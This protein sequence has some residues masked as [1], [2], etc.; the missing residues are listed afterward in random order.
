MSVFQ[1]SFWLWFY[2]LPRKIQDRT[3][4]ACHL[5]MKS[6]I[7][8]SSHGLGEQ[9]LLIDMQNSAH[10][11]VITQALV[12]QFYKRVRLRLKKPLTQKAKHFRTLFLF[13]DILHFISFPTI[14]RLT[15]FDLSRRANN[16][17]HGRHSRRYTVTLNIY[18][19]KKT[20]NHRLVGWVSWIP[21]WLQFWC[22]SKPN[23]SNWHGVI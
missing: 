1:I 22:N 8:K 4:D 2:R 20:M 15:Y 9:R 5:V 3:V 21:E 13:Q 17:F 19:C 16:F 6:N 18:T 10:A 7:R 14:Y 12:I 23:C 11:L